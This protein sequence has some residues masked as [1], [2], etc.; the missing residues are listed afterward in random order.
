[1]PVKK[2]RVEVYDE[3]NDLIGV[4]TRDIKFD[5]VTAVTVNTIIFDDQIVYDSQT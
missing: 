5:S 2:M 1:M 4:H 3:S